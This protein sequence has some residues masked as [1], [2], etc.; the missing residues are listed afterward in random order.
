MHRHRKPQGSSSPKRRPAPQ[1]HAASSSSRLIVTEPRPNEFGSLNKLEFVI[2]CRDGDQLTG[3][4][5]PF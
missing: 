1:V 2:A 4:P 3:T 5:L